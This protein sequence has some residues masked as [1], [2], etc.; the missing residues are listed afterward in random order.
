MPVPFLEVFTR[1][2]LADGSSTSTARAFLASA[3]TRARPLEL[4]FEDGSFDAATVGFGIRNVVDLPRALA[5]MRRVV[6]PGGQV[7]VL[8]ITT[9]ERPPLSWF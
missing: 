4:P 2:P 1:P 7:V 8:E 3:S 5:E 9:P 6:R